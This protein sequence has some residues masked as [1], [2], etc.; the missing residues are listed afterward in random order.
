MTE[1]INGWRRWLCAHGLHS[2]QD[3]SPNYSKDICGAVCSRGGCEARYLSER[4]RCAAGRR[5]VAA[6]ESGAAAA[7]AIAIT[8]VSEGPPCTD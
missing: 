8:A 6:I 7:G 3:L 5:K 1:I 2:W 4:E